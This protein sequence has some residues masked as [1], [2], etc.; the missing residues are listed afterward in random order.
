MLRA[1]YDRANAAWYL[2]RDKRVAQRAG[3]T[4]QDFRGKAEVVRGKI[5]ADPEAYKRETYPHQKERDQ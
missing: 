1:E 5:M 2:E 4:L 3:L